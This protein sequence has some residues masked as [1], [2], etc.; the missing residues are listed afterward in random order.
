MS[1][2]DDLLS[3]EI[4]FPGSVT[5]SA[6]LNCPYCGELLTVP[7][8]DPMGRESYQCCEC[9]GSFDVDWAE[10]QVHYVRQ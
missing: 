1:I 5:G 6:E 8:E 9:S 3:Y 2:F 10:G 4:C 7:V